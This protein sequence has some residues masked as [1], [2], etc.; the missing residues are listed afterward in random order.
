MNDLKIAILG[1]LMQIIP[2]SLVSQNLF[3]EN[4]S[5]SFTNYLFQT[6]QYNFASIELEKL[7]YLKPGNDSITFLLFKSYRLG[8]Q[9]DKGLLRS[10]QIYNKEEEI[11]FLPATEFCYLLISNKEYSASQQFINKNLSLNNG[12]K[13]R[14]DLHISLMNKDWKLA[15]QIYEK[16]LSMV[17][18]ISVYKPMIDESLKLKRKS[19]FLAGMFSTFV[20]GL[21]KVYTSFWKDGLLALLSIGTSSWQAYN[22]F[23]RNG[24][25]SAYGW[26]FGSLATVFYLSTIYGSQKS[27]KTFNRNQEDKILR[28]TEYLLPRD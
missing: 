12:F 21:G 19:P 20:P 1:F 24:S 3:D 10:R 18:G 17:Q 5:L 2:F 27:A 9:I 22:G 15:N 14:M 7:N 13:I 16:N 23:H 11:P 6:H 4:H 28:E 25:K 26:V 8:K